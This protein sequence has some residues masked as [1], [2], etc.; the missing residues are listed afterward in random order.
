MHHVLLYSLKTT[1]APRN[2]ENEGRELFL[3]KLQEAAESNTNCEALCK[4]GATFV[5]SR[6]VKGVIANL[7]DDEKLEIQVHV[8]DL[9]HIKPRI[10]RVCERFNIEDEACNDLYSYVFS[11]SKKAILAHVDEIRETNPGSKDANKYLLEGTYVWRSCNS[12]FKS[13]SN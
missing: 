4:D 13:Y 7:N 10:T 11:E 3:K 5:P 12:C 8:G 1:S 6:R 2:I 9:I